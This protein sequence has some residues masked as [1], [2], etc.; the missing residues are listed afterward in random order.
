MYALGSVIILN[1]HLPPASFYIIGA[2]IGRLAALLAAL[3]S[4]PQ[5][6]LQYGVG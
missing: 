3:V 6:A 4:L 2:R 1:S 5:P